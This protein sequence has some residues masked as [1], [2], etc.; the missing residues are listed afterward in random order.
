M[1]IDS[2]VEYYK[3]KVE[4][5]KLLFGMYLAL[6]IILILLSVLLFYKRMKV[7]LMEIT[8]ILVLLPF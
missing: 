6:V 7:E 3:G 8:N 2:T 4:F 1:L 5:Y